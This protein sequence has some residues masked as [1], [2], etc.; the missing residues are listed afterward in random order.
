M[1]QENVVE[2]VMDPNQMQCPRCNT[3]TSIYSNFCPLCRVSFGLKTCQLPVKAW[4][5]RIR[6]SGFPLATKNFIVPIKFI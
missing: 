4:V 6:V 5:T 2:N 3:L 1:K